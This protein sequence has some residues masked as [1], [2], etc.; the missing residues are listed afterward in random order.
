MGVSQRNNC[1]M[2]CNTCVGVHVHVHVNLPISCRFHQAGHFLALREREE[3]R[4]EG[5][6][7]EREGGRESR[8]GREWMCELYHSMAIAVHHMFM[9]LLP[10]ASPPP[11]A[12]HCNTCTCTCTRIY[13]YMYKGLHMYTTC[14]Q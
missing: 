5:R 7:G 3:G 14:T 2:L 9:P 12:I 8:E 13:M 4:E 1:V 10:V 6:E 11:S